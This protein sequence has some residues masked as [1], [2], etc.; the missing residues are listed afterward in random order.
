M[1]N[2]QSVQ[3]RS[4]TTLT[5]HQPRFTVGR[6]RRGNWIVQDREGMV[7][8]LFAN[9]TAALHFAVEE[10]NHNPGDICRAPEGAVL[11]FGP[12]LTLVNLH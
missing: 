10:S 11:D 7:G 4:P 1:A 8:G 12:N 2:A 6:D 3:Y 9:E 5:A